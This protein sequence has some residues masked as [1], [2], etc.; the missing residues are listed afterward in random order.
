[1]YG[2]YNYTW[3]LWRAN[4]IARKKNNRAPFKI[5]LLPWFRQPLGKNLKQRPRI[6][7]AHAVRRYAHSQAYNI[8]TITAVAPSA[9]DYRA[10]RDFARPFMPRTH[11]HNTLYLYR[12]PCVCAIIVGNRPIC[13]DVVLL[14][15]GF[16]RR[17]RATGATHTRQTH[18]ETDGRL[19]FSRPRIA[20]GHRTAARAC[21]VSYDGAATRL[22]APAENR[23]DAASPMAARGHRSRRLL[24]PSGGGIWKGARDANR[25]YRVNFRFSIF[26]LLFIFLLIFNRTRYHE[27]MRTI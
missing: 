4:G 18:P 9:A 26:F 23:G 8:K 1:M 3:R 16:S 25:G 14:S 12:C 20:H 22:V 17:P 6:L 10:V 7:S 2:L 24:V 11:V 19:H 5:G 15:C 21:V 13:R 27:R